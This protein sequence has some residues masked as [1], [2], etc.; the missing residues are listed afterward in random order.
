MRIVN[1]AMGRFLI[2]AGSEDLLGQFANRRSGENRPDDHNDEL[3]AHTTLIK[4]ILLGSAAGFS[5][6]GPSR[7]F[8]K[9]D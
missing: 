6:K 2:A 8:A 1:G 3:E 7:A 5:R 9:R 4:S